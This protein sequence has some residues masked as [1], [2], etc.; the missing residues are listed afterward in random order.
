[1]V[2]HDGTASSSRTAEL[3]CGTEHAHSRSNFRYRLDKEK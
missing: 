2:D 1:M 3:V